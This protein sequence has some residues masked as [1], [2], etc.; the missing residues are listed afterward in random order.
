MQARVADLLQQSRMW[1]LSEQLRR[2]ELTS[3][4]KQLDGSKSTSL[5]I[6]GQELEALP[7]V[8]R[9]VW[10][11]QRERA[12][13]SLEDGM[14]IADGQVELLRHIGSG[15]LSEVWKGRMVATNEAVAVKF[16]LPTVDNGSEIAKSFQLEV[17]RLQSLSGIAFPRVLLPYT[18]EGRRHFYAISYFADV[19]TFEDVL[20]DNSVTVLARVRTIASVATGLHSMHVQGFVHGDVKPQNILVRESGEALLIDFGATRRFDVT[21]E[22]ETV[23][24]TYAFAAPE[25]IGAGRSR[26]GASSKRRTRARLSA[27]SLGPWTDLYSLGIILFH[28]LDP[29]LATLA[30]M[31]EQGFI[32]QLVVSRDLKDVIRRATA[33]DPNDRFHSAL[34]FRDALDKAVEPTADSLSV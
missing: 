33:H 22:D 14:L 25:L 13:H 20:R 21:D 3:T 26:S 12:S 11:N 31:E 29:A 10:S 4:P 19:R 27:G 32:D 15:S 30:R 9:A 2:I 34:D 7:S 23:T 16:L 24:F 17:V 18:V 5:E 28:A 6:V 8:S 1:V